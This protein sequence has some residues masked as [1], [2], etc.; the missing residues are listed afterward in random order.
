MEEALE[1]GNQDLRPVN[2]QI[3]LH[4]SRLTIASIESP[5]CRAVSSSVSDLA[6]NLNVQILSHKSADYM[7]GTG[8]ENEGWEEGTGDPERGMKAEGTEGLARDCKI[9]EEIAFDFCL[10]GRC[11]C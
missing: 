5:S 9:V 11:P 6:D 3:A 10:D 1:E 7:E 8:A 2:D 4:Q